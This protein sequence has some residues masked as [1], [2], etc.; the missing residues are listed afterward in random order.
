MISLHAKTCYRLSLFPIIGEKTNKLIDEKGFNLGVFDD[1]DEINVEEYEREYDLIFDFYSSEDGIE[2]A[3]ATESAEDIEDNAL[4][5]DTSKFN[6][7]ED[8]IE[9]DEDFILISNLEEPDGL[10][11]NSIEI[12]RD[13]KKRQDDSSEDE[14]VDIIFDA[15]C[16]RMSQVAEQ[17]VEKGLAKD[18]ESVKFA[19]QFGPATRVWY[20]FDICT[21]EFAPELLRT[22]DCTD[23]NDCPA[24]ETLYNHWPDR[25]LGNIIY[26]G[27]FYAGNCEQ[28]EDYHFNIDLVNCDLQSLL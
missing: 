27:K 14:H 19:L 1:L 22:I 13:M 23:W 28:M 24:C 26:D 15:I 12:F 7:E 25:L 16:R 21:D 10:D 20:L 3:V 5:I 6:L 2:C 4:S 9:P 8:E 18:V 17:L 11:S